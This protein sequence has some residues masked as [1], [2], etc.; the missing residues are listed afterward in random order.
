M[1]GGCGEVTSVTCSLPSWTPVVTGQRDLWGIGVHRK[2][3]GDQWTGS[4]PCDSVTGP[5]TVTAGVVLLQ[6]KLKNFLD[7]CLSS[8]HVHTISFRNTH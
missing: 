2:V 6:L 7:T 3:L 5:T 1:F 8:L 4:K